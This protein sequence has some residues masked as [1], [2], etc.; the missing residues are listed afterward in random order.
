MKIVVIEPLGVETSLLEE[1]AAGLSP[2]QNLCVMTHE[3]KTLKNLSD[4]GLMLTL[5]LSQ[6]SRSQKKS[7]PDGNRQK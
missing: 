1:L 3:A 4:A 5:L 2:R 6:I 7:S